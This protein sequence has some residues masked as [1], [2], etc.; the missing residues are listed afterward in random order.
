MYKFLTLLFLLGLTSFCLARDTNYSRAKIWF[1]GKSAADLAR[2]GIDVTEGELRPGVW[3]ISDFSEYEIVKIQRAGFRVD[4]LIF[5]I[6]KYYRDRN[7]ISHAGRLLNTVTCDEVDPDYAVPSHFYLGSMGGFYTYA[8]LLDILDSMALEFP[9]LISFKQAVDTT[10]TI[11]GRP[12]YY[13]KISDNPTVDETE[14]E[15]LYTA[16][17]HAREPESMSQLIYY[18]WYLLENYAADSTVRNLVDNTEMYF[19]PCINPDGYIYNETTDPA[20]GGMWRKNRRDNLDGEYGVDINR[21]YGWQWGLD[22]IGSSP[23]T[24]DGTYRGTSGFSEPETQAIR[25]FTNRHEFRL[26]LNYHTYGNFHIVPWGYGT[27][28]FTPDSLQFDFYSEALTKYNHFLIGTPNQTVNYTVN[29]NSDDWMYGDQTF[30][31]KILSMTPEVGEGNDGFWPATNRIVDLCKGSMYAN[32]T[33]ARL[34][35]R[36]GVIQHNDMHTVTALSNEFVFD[37]QLLGLD[38]SGA[39]SVTLVPLSSSILSAGSPITFSGLTTL[40]LVRDSIQ[41]TLSPAVVPGDLI[42]FAVVV[43]N[44]LFTESDT[45]ES[46]YGSPVTL[47]SD[48]CSSLSAWNSGS[49]NWDITT[50]DFV[51]PGTS[52]TDSP[53]SDYLPNSVNQLTLTNVVSLSGAVDAVLS[54]DTKWNIEAGYDYAQVLVSPDQGANWTALCGKYTVTG[55]SN[56][57][58]GEPLYDGNQAQWVHEEVNLADYLG[59]DLMF[60]FQITS[61]QFQEGDGFY[62]DN[63]EVKTVSNTTGFHP[64]ISSLPVLSAAIPNPTTGEST[65]N[66]SLVS[67]GSRFLVYNS[68]GQK[69]MDADISGPSGKIRIPSQSFANGMY[70]YFISMADGSVSPVMKLIVQK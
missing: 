51:S 39:I 2:V 63:F 41:Y 61:D 1:D 69:V 49:T 10:L 22:D 47:I 21:N 16:I 70:S 26:A 6:R 23:L 9:G 4:I 48:D 56:Q 68:F 12:V 30:R 67:Q 52:M 33:L 59:L 46:V 31:S 57:A 62:F 13:V 50:E 42:R 5:N 14:P 38:T 54:F 3:F 25:N 58:V 66:Y 17:H 35:G 55:N 40:Q 64:A 20:G 44:G 15:V 28:F 8:Q 53:F 37:F 45:V 29:G 27:N 18:M 60:R 36:Y 43:D 34:A 24:G 65:V 32:L 19:V 11:E 7:S